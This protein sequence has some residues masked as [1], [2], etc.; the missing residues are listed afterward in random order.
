VPLAVHA[1]QGTALPPARPAA[2]RP[3]LLLPAPRPLR[4]TAEQ[5]SCDGPLTLV[6]GPE[7]IEAGWWDFDSPAAGK[8]R[9]AV[10]RDYFVARN[11]QGQLLW[12]FRELTAPRGWFLHGFFA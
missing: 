2:P 11:P 9:Q 12:I 10:H 1:Q 3:L 6:T 8:P 4:A 7:R 5:P